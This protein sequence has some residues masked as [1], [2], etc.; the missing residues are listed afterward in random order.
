MSRESRCL[1]IQLSVRIRHERRW[2]MGA[3]KP[4]LPGVS[5]VCSACILVGVE[6]GSKSSGQ[7]VGPAGLLW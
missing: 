6:G 2:A 3:R 7:V 5:A 4:I 1:E